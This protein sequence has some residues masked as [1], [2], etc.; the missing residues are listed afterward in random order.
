MES[1][2]LEPGPRKAVGRYPLLVGSVVIALII[3]AIVGALTVSSSHHSNSVSVGEAALVSAAAQ[4]TI[5]ERTADLT[6]SGVVQVAGHTV[7][8]QGTGSADFG[9]NAMTMQIRAVAAGEAL[10]ENIE[11][12]GGNLFFEVTV[13]GQGLA[14]ADGGKPWVQLPI[15]SSAG[16]SLSANPVEELAVMEQRGASV[17]SLGTKNIGGEVCTGYAV[18]PSKAATVAT[19]QAEV[20]KLGVPAATQATIMK[21]VE[22][23]APPT[24]DIW[25][26][27]QQLARQINV[28]IEMSVGASA[29]LAGSV[30]L[31]FARYGVP[32][33]IKT[34]PAAQTISYQDLLKR[35]GQSSSA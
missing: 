15:A 3:A 5:S 32:V 27:S 4:R 1:H 29:P 26:N 9:T 16:G 33:S 24:Y 14:Q 17:R 22:S 2:Y 19:A 12:S 7:P 13:N 23:S 34:P 28:A 30:V 31:D 10:V 6:V 25:I 18:R 35:L 8:M 20:A 21:M 11:Y